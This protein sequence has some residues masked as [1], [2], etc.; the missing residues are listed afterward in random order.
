MR[1]LIDGK[2]IVDVDPAKFKHQ[3]AVVGPT[4]N[5]IGKSFSLDFSNGGYIRSPYEKLLNIQV[6]VNSCGN[7]ST[8]IGIT[9]KKVTSER[10]EIS[11]RNDCRCRDY[12]V[13][14]LDNGGNLETKP[15]KRCNMRR[16][17]C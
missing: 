17:R 1:H 4:G 12:P 14:E 8:R 2:A 6:N 10:L 7:F 16:P 11:C 5:L 3:A 13:H 9:H 15:R